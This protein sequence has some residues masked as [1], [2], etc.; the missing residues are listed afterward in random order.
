VEFSTLAETLV[1]LGNYTDTARIAEE[2]PRTFPGDWQACHQG[3]RFLLGCV[4]LV[5]RDEQMSQADRTAL[6]RS[7]L[8]SARRFASGSHWPRFQ[9]CCRR[10]GSGE[11]GNRRI[12]GVYSVAAD[13]VR[14]GPGNDGA[15]GFQLWCTT[16][17]HGFVV[18]EIAVTN[19][20]RYR[21]GVYL[22]KGPRL[23]DRGTLAGRDSDRGV[24]STDLLPR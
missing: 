10:S 19:S 17:Q 7:Y 12:S 3:A 8:H 13:D 9:R 11:S 23:R 24:V 15:N 6:G 2:L 5:T 14:V 1:Q 18:L 20:G 22:T 16:Q 4:G 21:L